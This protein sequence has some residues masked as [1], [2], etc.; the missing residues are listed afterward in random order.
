MISRAVIIKDGEVLLIHRFRPHMEYYVVPGGHIEENESEEEALIREVKE[1]T[2]LDVKIEKRLWS[3]EDPYHNAQH[4][5]FLVTEFTGEIQ[6][7]GPEAERNCEENKY[8]LEWHDLA[9]VKSLNLLPEDM[10]KLFVEM[11]L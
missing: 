7:G 1:E 3:L 9:D 6:L 5:F 2:N 11:F 10:K 8:I 4:H